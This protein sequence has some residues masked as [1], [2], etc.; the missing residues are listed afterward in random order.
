MMMIILKIGIKVRIPV[1]IIINIIIVTVIINSC[2][3]PL[4]SIIIAIFHTII[5]AAA[6]ANK[7]AVKEVFSGNAS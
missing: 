4:Y 1:I 6:P 5:P 3:I 7:L 2:R